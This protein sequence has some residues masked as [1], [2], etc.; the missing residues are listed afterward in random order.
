MNFTLEAQTLPSHASSAHVNHLAAPWIFA[1]EA[2][3]L[4]HDSTGPQSRCAHAPEPLSHRLGSE[5]GDTAAVLPQYCFNLRKGL[6]GSSNKED[7]RFCGRVMLV[8]RTRTIG[9]DR[10][11]PILAAFC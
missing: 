8:I 6:A 1:A 3:R 7:L 4:S 10:Y 9:T 11:P 5:P 2:S